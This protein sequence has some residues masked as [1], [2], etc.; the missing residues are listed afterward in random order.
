MYSFTKK[1]RLLFSHEYD[2]VFSRGKKIVSRHFIFF[3]CKNDFTYA[4]LGLAI[5]KKRVAKSHE[6]QRIKRLV[7]ESFRHSMLS[8][9]D[10]VV[11][12]KYGAENESNSSLLSQLGCVW[13]DLARV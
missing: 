4:R 11:L 3:C 2:L 6:R 12:A 7:R 10:I 13:G 8:G 9:L 1:K 5:S